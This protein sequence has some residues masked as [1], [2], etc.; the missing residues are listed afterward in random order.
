V[1]GRSRGRKV[2]WEEAEMKVGMDLQTKLTVFGAGD[3]KELEKEKLG[4]RGGEQNEVGIPEASEQ[5]F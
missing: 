5:K 1:G 3:K 2:T 4:W